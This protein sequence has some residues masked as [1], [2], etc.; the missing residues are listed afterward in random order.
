MYLDDDT[1]GDDGGL[2]LALNRHATMVADRDFKIPEEVEV[3]FVAL[4]KAV[5]SY[6]GLKADAV[7][8]SPLGHAYARFMS[9]SKKHYEKEIGCL[10]YT[11][12]FY[13]C[14]HIRLMTGRQDVEVGMKGNKNQ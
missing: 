7:P 10:Y 9:V 13:A 12:F 5:E 8:N 2:F 3:A 11:F 1:N 4:R 6:W 14:M